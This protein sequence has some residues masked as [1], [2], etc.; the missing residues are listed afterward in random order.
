[1]IKRLW[2]LLGKYK[3][4]LVI[5][6]VLVILEIIF[7][8]QIPVLM[9]N[10]IDIGIRG[11]GGISYVIKC[12][13]QMVFLA[14]LA[15]I[16]GSTSG[17]LSS[18]A[19]AGLSKEM[20]T[21]MFDKIQDYS[22]S[23]IDKFSTPSLLTRLTR[24]VMEVRMAF[25]QAA[26]IM[27]RG[28]LMLILT[29]ILAIRISPSLALILLAAIPALGITFFLVF[30]NAHPIFLVMMSKFDK[31]NANIQENLIGIRVVKTFVRGDYEI[32][33]FVDSA[34]DVRD[35]QAKAERI[36]SFNRLMMEL[37]IYC[38]IL[39][40][41]W[42][43]GHMM[44]SEGLTTGEFTR[45]MS[46]INQIMMQLMM[47]NMATVQL[48]TCETSAERIFEVMDEEID[49]TEELANPN[50]QVRDGSVSFEHVNFSY[51]KNREN[52]TL[53]DINLEIASGE[54][55]G[56]IGSTGVG[57]SALVQ[58][59]PRLYDVMD[60]CV[61][62]GGIDVRQYEKHTL[63]ESVAM[64]LQKNVLFAG[65]IMENLRWGNEKATDEE[66]YA[67]CRA[68]CAH[69]FIQSM[70]EGYDTFLGQGGVNL[71]GG[72][73]QRVCIARALIKKPKIMILDDSTSAV[74]TAT[75]AS[76]RKALK[77][78]L[79]GMTTILIA[80]RVA[81]VMEADKILVMENGKIRDMGNHETLMQQSDIY[82]ELYESQQ[83]GVE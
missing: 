43:G 44:V 80:Q 81:S 47:L 31:L 5:S 36:I 58:L 16:F 14:L 52:L 75:D 15:L 18:R 39:A 42:F 73:K 67:A 59:I 74:D 38:C 60:G 77:E 64:V 6:T 23:N 11:D 32:D 34:E 49:I 70:P 65:T 35:T 61:R 83:K 68:A 25:I 46:Y 48:V 1:M 13:V 28:P 40:V 3:K 69:D 12:G 19:S 62:V 9:Q 45:F 82:R 20:R 54:T 21:A 17:I 57:K 51:S 29:M 2:N 4:L 37:T 7:D 55:V 24:D 50:N 53:E 26:R 79:A 63:R 76:I 30:K 72:Q 10:I 27:I 78:E 33:K 56:I 22:F 8:L 41:A 66:V 71:S